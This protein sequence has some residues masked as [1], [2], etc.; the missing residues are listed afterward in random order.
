MMKI[1]ARAGLVSLAILL[2][3]GGTLASAQGP[4]R[5]ATKFYPDFSDTADTLL[6]NA[7][8]HV[9]DGQWAEAVEIYQRVIQQ[10]GD[11]VARLPKDDAAED[12]TGDSLLFVDLRQFCQRRIAALPPEARAIYRNRVDSQAERWYRDGAEGRDRSLLRRVVDQAF[13][14]SW[15]DDALDLLGD[16]AF[17]DGRFDEALAMYRRLVPD[18]PDDL[19]GLT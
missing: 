19:T 10:Y 8:S 14:S 16:L 11:K 3:F 18:R 13:C 2:N 9:R 6:R 15:G 7:T 4:N 17:E 12:R 5:T 1:R